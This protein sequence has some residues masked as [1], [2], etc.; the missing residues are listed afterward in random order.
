MG[1]KSLA[2]RPM[3]VRLFSSSR[4]HTLIAAYLIW[5]V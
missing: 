4:R 5:Q 3:S 1:R 2:T